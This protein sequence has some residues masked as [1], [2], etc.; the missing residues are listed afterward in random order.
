VSVT[1][2]QATRVRSRDL[3]GHLMVFSA[4]THV[5]PRPEDLRPY[6]PARHLAAYDDFV[7]Q[8][9]EQY[10]QFFEMRA[11]SD[12]YWEGRRRNALTDGHFD[13]DAWLHD[14]DRDGV[15][16][17]VIFHD[18]LNG[19]PMPFDLMNSLGN[20]IPEPEARELAG[21]GR[22]M[23][24][25]WLADFTAATGGRGLGLAQL[26]FWDVDASI[27]ELE[28][29]A[30][31]GFGGVNFPAPG[32]PGM[33]QPGH[34]DLDRFFA[35]C[36]SLDMTL[37]T[38][39]GAVPPQSEYGDPMGEA[40]F[41]F[42]LLDSGE[43]GVRTVYQLVIFGIFERH[44]GLR[45][46]LTEVPGVFW[47]EMCVKMDSLHDS[48]IRRR[49]HQTARRPSEYAATNVWMGNSFQSRQEAEA[50]IAIGRADRFMWGSDYPHAEGTYI[51]TDD[52][53]V[54]PRT[55]LS[56]AYN[57][58]GLPIAEVRKLLGEN[59]LVAFPRLDVDALDCA[60]ARTGFC[61]DELAAAPVLSDHPDIQGTGT[62]AFRSEGPWS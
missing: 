50:A 39:I 58:H 20:G 2:S 13:P 5:G 45:L 21:V 23:Y 31:R 61:E 6:C 19:Q 27:A 44:P 56:L 29:C 42:G 60:A 38:H 16:G 4:D 26:P 15:A 52:P 46:V 40:T 25:R 14:M 49:D 43:W 62:L 7:T 28:A 57:Y 9:G 11:F 35:A 17:G 34:P 8:W 54:Y 32:Q 59:A 24:N 10:N 48:P 37:A 41:H 47:N 53:E 22:Q 36:A 1:A 3:G 12:D 33:R 18:S 30:E 51:H 55:R